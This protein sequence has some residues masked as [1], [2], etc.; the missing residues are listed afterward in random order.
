MFD[1]LN[2]IS[3]VIKLIIIII[4]ITYYLII[5]ILRNKNSK[6]QELVM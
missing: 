5:L 6:L 4:I 2:N 3:L 1:F